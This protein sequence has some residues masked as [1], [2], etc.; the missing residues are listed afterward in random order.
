MNAPSWNDAFLIG[1]PEID[2]EHRDLFVATGDL[3]DVTWSHRRTKIQP[4]LRVISDHV[5]GHFN[6][7]E[8]LMRQAGYSGYLWHRQQHS[9][10]AR[11]LADL[12]Q[13]ARCGGGPECERLVDFIGSWLPDHIR[14]HDR[15]MSAS[16]RNF[17]RIDRQR[18][19]AAHQRSLS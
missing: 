11:R 19:I 9:T 3:C 6:H 2:E 4:L 13:A 18:K 7:E 8:R 15:M 14:V 12:I 10:A 1:I 5:V 17:R 16:L